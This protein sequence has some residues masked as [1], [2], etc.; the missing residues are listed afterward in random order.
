MTVYIIKQCC[1]LIKE[2]S[3]LHSCVYRLYSAA[4]PITLVLLVQ[5]LMVSESLERGLLDYVCIK[6]EIYFGPVFDAHGLFP[7]WEIMVRYKF[8]TL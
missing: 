8:N 5:S 1:H 3:E 7:K 2:G 4:R 6:S